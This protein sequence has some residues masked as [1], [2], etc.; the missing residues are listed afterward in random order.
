MILGAG[1]DE[2]AAGH[3]EIIRRY[4]TSPRTARSWPSPAGPIPPTT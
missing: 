4:S 2:V 1:D 3:D